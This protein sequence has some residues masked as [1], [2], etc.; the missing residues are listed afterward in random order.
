MEK[1][2][3]LLTELNNFNISSNRVFDI[4]ENN[5]SRKEKFGKIHLDKING[6]FKFENVTFGYEQNNNVLKDLSFSVKTG[7]TV[8][9]IGKSGAGKTTIF[10]IICKLYDINKGKIFIDNVDI[11]ELDEDTIRSN[12]SIINQ[13]PYIF[14]LSIKDNFKIVKS[15]VTDEE[16]E[17]ACKLACIDEFINSLPYKYDTII[18][19]N[20]VLLS[21][22]QK[23]RIAIA[24][25]LIKK[26]P[27]ILF[28]EA[29]SALDNET[30]KNIQ[31]AIENL[32][33]YSTILIIAHRL[34]TIINCD[35][36]L[37][38]EDGKIAD[39]GKHIELIE[40]NENYRRLCETELIK[41][42]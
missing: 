7:E 22:G 40:K 39:S 16:I 27:I 37:I 8:A 17:E 25:A 30:Q 33:K 12:I 23:Q 3:K 15:D 11:N 24:R 13:N 26:T 1:I 21:G 14:N 36:I 9:I 38:L 6:N 35:R 20:G 31:M 41:N 18:G 34:S 10:N 2:T 4:I 19:E 28:D 32:K 5:E 42:V 29:T